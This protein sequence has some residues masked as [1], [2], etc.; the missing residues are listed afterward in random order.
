MGLKSLE[1]QVALPRSQDAGKVQ[2]QVNR[3]GEQLQHTLTHEQLEQEK[4]KR[5]QI[6][7]QEEINS[8]KLK[9]DLSH[10]EKPNNN[11]EETKE[12]E[13]EINHPFL[14]KRIDFN[15]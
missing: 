1:M 2:D 7:K 8:L 14:G 5:T 10:R 12:K 15:G 13:Q 3:Q 11:Q 4:K 6:Q 9:K